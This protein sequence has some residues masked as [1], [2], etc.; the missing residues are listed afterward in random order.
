M[1]LNVIIII[2]V[3]CKIY[4]TAAEQQVTNHKFMETNYL[5][6]QEIQLWA[7]ISQI[8]FKAP[9]T[10]NTIIA[11][12]SKYAVTANDKVLYSQLSEL[13]QS[14]VSYIIPKHKEEK[15]TIC[16]LYSAIRY[17][18]DPEHLQKRSIDNF[19][20]AASAVGGSISEIKQ[21]LQ[22]AKCGSFYNGL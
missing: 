15:T 1:F 14:I 22:E 19:R 2:T 5:P 9:F 20:I 4:T 6:V 10:N 11:D 16:H 18:S 12:L 21:N 7:H 3:G 17:S 13:L 8:V